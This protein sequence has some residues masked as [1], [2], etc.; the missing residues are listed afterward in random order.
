MGVVHSEERRGG[1]YDTVFKERDEVG[2]RP[3]V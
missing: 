2:E 3:R 1:G